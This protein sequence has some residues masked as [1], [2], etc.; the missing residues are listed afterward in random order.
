LRAQQV[1]Q[2]GL[3]V[4][5]GGADDQVAVLDRHRLRH[6][7]GLVQGFA[8]PQQQVVVDGAAAV[9]DHLHG[10]I[11]RIEVGSGVEHRQQ[12]D[13]CGEH[14]FPGRVLKHGRQ[15]LTARDGPEW[16]RVGTAQADFNVP[17]GSTAVMAWRWTL[18]VTLGAISTVTRES[19]SS[20]MRPAL[21]PLVITSS[22]FSSLLSSSRCSLARFICGRIRKNQK[23]TNIRPIMIRPLYGLGWAGVPTAWAA[24][25]ETRKSSRFMDLH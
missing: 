17:L 3:L 22:P 14:I 24:A 2:L 11:L 20:V 7:A 6:Q 16:L 13:H 12:D 5:V 21:P 15:P 8:Y 1:G 9:G 4:E 10:R 25:G 23:N 19:P 18:M